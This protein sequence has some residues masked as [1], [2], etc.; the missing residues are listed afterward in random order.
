MMETLEEWKELKGF[1]GRYSISSYG[2]C[3]EN[4][5]VSKGILGTKK[6]KKCEDKVFRGVYKKNVT[7]EKKALARKR[8]NGY[9]FQ[10]S[11]IEI[12]K[13]RVKK[14]VTLLVAEHFLPNPLNRERIR[15]VDGNPSNNR[16]DNLKWSGWGSEISTKAEYITRLKNSNVDWRKNNETVNSII[17]YL[18]GD[19]SEIEKILKEN[20]RKIFWV[21]YKKTENIPLAEDLTQE[22]LLKIYQNINK[23]LFHYPQNPIGWFIRTAQN[24]ANNYLN[25][26]QIRLVSYDSEWVN[27]QVA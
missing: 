21:I 15:W 22:S 5:Y 23:L 10:L 9:Y 18:E 11:N 4:F 3:I 12:G 26:K 24:V 17:K 20:R 16:A 14:S 1:G 27:H 7:K 8:S 6:G 25:K 19:N 2:R 13:K